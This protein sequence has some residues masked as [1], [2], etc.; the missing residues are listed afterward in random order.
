VGALE[1]LGVHQLLESVHAPIALEATHG[2]VQFP[3]HQPVQGRHR[4]AVAQVRLVFNNDRTTVA[5]S[6][7][8]RAAAGERTPEEFF[9]HGEIIG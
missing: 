2:V 5:S 9:H 4:R 1:V 8:H 7:Y 6:H 3:V